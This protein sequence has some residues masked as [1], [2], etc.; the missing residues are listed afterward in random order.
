[1]RPGSKCVALRT[2]R[3]AVPQFCLMFWL[4]LKLRADYLMSHETRLL[5]TAPARAIYSSFL[6]LLFYIKTHIIK[7]STLRSYER[8]SGVCAH[9]RFFFFN[10]QTKEHS[11]IS[12][13]PHPSRLPSNLFFHN[14]QVIQQWERHRLGQLLLSS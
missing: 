1:M 13:P 14:K 3:K 12:P 7:K 4:P 6:L 8:T 9:I 11:N 2:S 5:V 10:N